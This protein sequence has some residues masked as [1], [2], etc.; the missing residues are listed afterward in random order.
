MDWSSSM[1][2]RSEEA[3]DEVGPL[4][5]LVV[6]VG[7]EAESLSHKTPLYIRRSPLLNR[8]ECEEGCTFLWGTDGPKVGGG[9]NAAEL[10]GGEPSL[11][12]AA[13]DTEMRHKR[14][15]LRIIL[16]WMGLFGYV[17]FNDD[18]SWS[19]CFLQMEL[20]CSMP[21]VSLDLSHRTML[22]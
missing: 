1:L 19:Q 15:F 5:S 18:S 22:H 11:I 20:L 7:S 2:C 4:S 12:V 6:S 8:W 21:K 13:A 17:H 16:G 10:C 3:D 9:T 14:R